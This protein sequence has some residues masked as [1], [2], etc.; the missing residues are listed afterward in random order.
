MTDIKIIYNPVDLSVRLYY[1]N[2]E[3]KS[4]ENKIYAFIKTEGFFNCLKPFNRRY[5]IWNGLLT[6]LIDEFNDDE[7]HIIFEGREKDFKEVESA[8]EGSRTTVENVGYENNWNLMFIKNFET[9]NIAES[10]VEIAGDLR[11]LCETRNELYVINSYVK[12][13]H[14]LNIS[15]SYERLEALI[16]EH[17]S[18]WEDSNSKYK[19]S[20]LAFLAHCKKQLR[21]VSKY[22]R[23]L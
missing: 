6:E 2:K 14:T 12:D 5:V 13:M 18:K 20:K 16:E 15:E 17:I 23:S 22:I 3:I 1:D 9:E 8:F 7:L 4:D 19:E 21:D 10:L 11:E